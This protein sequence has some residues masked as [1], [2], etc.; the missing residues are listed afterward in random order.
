[1]RVTPYKRLDKKPFR[2]LK[3][4]EKMFRK[5]LTMRLKMQP[6]APKLPLKE[7]K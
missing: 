1:M 7:L 6:K 4:P 3:Q 2:A 5:A